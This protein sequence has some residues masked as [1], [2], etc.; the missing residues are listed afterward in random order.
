MS[1]SWLMF[2]NYFENSIFSKKSFGNSLELPSCQFIIGGGTFGKCSKLTDV[3]FFQKYFP[4]KNSPS[5]GTNVLCLT[6]EK[7]KTLKGLLLESLKKTTSTHH[8]EKMCVFF[9]WWFGWRD[10]FRLLVPRDPNGSPKR[11]AGWAVGG[12][13]NHRNEN[14]K[15]LASMKPFSGKVMFRIPRNWLSLA[16][17]CSPPPCYDILLVASWMLI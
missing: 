7:K 17:W 10:F 14:A 5:A 1:F 11:Q 8:N 15:Y 12:G 9:P 13:S 16:G 6:G 4:Q 2:Q 3:L